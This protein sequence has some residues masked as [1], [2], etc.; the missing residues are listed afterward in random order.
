[1]KLT[2]HSPFLAFAI[3]I[4]SLWA[5]N[6]PEL[7]YYR[8]EGTGSKVIN[9]A[10]NPPAGTDTANIIGNI[11]QI[12][13]SP[14]CKGA[15]QG[16]ATNPAGSQI[17]THYMGNFQT[18]FTISFR[19]HGITSD[20]SGLLYYVFGN[21]SLGSLRCFTNGVA[22]PNNFILRGPFPDILVLGNALSTQTMTSFVYDHIAG[23]IKAYANENLVSTTNVAPHANTASTPFTVFGYSSN[24]SA[25]PT[26]FLDEFRLYDRA[27]SDLEIAEL[28]SS[29]IPGSL[30]PDIIF[31]S[32]SVIKPNLIISDV[33]YLWSNGSTADS[34]TVNSTD[35][36]SLFISGCVSGSDTIRFQDQTT[37][38]SYTTDICF[39]A[40]P[41][42]SPSGTL[43]TG[44]GN[45]FDTIPNAAGCDSIISI[46]LQVENIDLSLSQSGTSGEIISSNAVANQYQWINCGTNSPIAGATSAQFTATENGSYAL[47]LS[48]INCTDTTSC[49]QV[50]TLGN[51]AYSLPL[52]FNL[53]P[54]PTNDYIAVELSN[55]SNLSYTI[56]LFNAVGQ[57]IQSWKTQS[58]L[59]SLEL[60]TSPGM[61]TLKVTAP[62]G[63]SSQKQI[64]KQ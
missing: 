33:D 8:F 32:E 27:L 9:Y 23:H 45:Y 35:S 24:I 53:F 11:T 12:P 39:K 2:L 49:M 6:T 62:N 41:Y 26:G 60:N 47:V 5:Q 63:Q 1:M 57:K 34:V 15:M 14:L 48:T 29:N 56:E 21:T 36:I 25:P 42:I 17:N 52:Q 19:S 51:S 16:T 18:S 59:T 7:L 4:S 10:S 43:Y 61:Y 30:G 20:A 55:H 37:T 28:Y 54:N 40:L 46:Q 50:Y 64:I 38:H 31:C 58:N 13:N 3:G 44:A 22:G